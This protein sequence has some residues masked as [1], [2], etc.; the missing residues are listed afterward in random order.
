MK[1]RDFDQ[2]AKNLSMGGSR[3]EVIKGLG[4]ALAGGALAALFSGYASAQP[5]CR[6]EG[7]PCE[8]NQV[9]CPGL[10]CKPAAGPGQ[11]AR[12]TSQKK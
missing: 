5:G 10:V 4:R 7:H 11:A 8:G 3:R 1:A 6:R 12:C 2:L 9:C